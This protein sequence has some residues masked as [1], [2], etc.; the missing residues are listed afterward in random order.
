MIQK[1]KYNH[2][3][4]R[5]IDIWNEKSFVFGNHLFEFGIVLAELNDMCSKLKWETSIWTIAWMCAYVYVCVCIRNILSSSVQFTFN[6][7][8]FSHLFSLFIY[9]Y[10]YVY[11]FVVSFEFHDNF[12]KNKYSAMTSIE[13]N[14]PKCKI[15]NY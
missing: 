4:E 5:I 10:T 3:F 12:V 14:E 2:S 1:K 13:N 7:L 9:L 15:W 11:L 8:S 6:E